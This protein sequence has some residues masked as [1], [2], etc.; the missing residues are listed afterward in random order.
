MA[1]MLF[2]VSCKKRYLKLEYGWAQN[3]KLASTTTENKLNAQFTRRGSEVQVLYRPPGG[4]SAYSNA[5]KS[6]LEGGAIIQAGS[7]AK[8]WIVR[9]PL[10]MIFRTIINTGL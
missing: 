8:E 10:L 1:K 2:S 4:Y 5:D 9:A 3:N 6:N 7:G